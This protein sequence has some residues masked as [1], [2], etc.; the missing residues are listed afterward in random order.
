[1]SRLNIAFVGVTRAEL[2]AHVVDCTP[3]SVTV[4]WGC[5]I[6]LQEGLALLYKK[7]FFFYCGKSLII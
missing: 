7:C 5:S 4:Q 1:M 6:S 2:D 3:G